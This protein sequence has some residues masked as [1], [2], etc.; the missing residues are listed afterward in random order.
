MRP[1]IASNTPKQDVKNMLSSNSKND[2]TRLAKQQPRKHLQRN[3]KTSFIC[4]QMESQTSKEQ[5]LM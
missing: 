5:T 2:R 1:K 4:L 3:G